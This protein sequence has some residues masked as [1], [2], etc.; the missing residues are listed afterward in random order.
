[1][2]IPFMFAFVVDANNSITRVIKIFGIIIGRPIGY[3]NKS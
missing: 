3:R 2:S 1:M